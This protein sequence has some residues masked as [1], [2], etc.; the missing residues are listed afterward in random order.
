[1]LACLLVVVLVLVLEL[2][3][4]GPYLEK[5][6]RKVLLTGRCASRF[7]FTFTLHAFTYEN[8]NAPADRVSTIIH[9]CAVQRENENENEDGEGRSVQ[10]IFS[11]LTGVNRKFRY[12]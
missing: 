1:M 6:R 4:S 2:V 5:V 3:V 8:L 7:T 12:P 11:F 9:G 10:P